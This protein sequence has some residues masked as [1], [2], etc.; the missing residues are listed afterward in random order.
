MKRSGIL[1]EKG[2]HAF[3]DEP[4]L[5][6]GH[7]IPRIWIL[8][9][10]RKSAHIYRRASSGLELIASSTARSGKSKPQ[11]L[12]AHGTGGG[13]HHDHDPVHEARHHQDLAFARGLSDWLE[14]AVR[15]RVVDRVVLIA[16][17]E[18]LGHLRA[19]FPKNVT[20]CVSAELR[21]DLVSL[22]EKTIREHLKD[23]VWF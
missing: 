3:D 13:I 23:I 1:I 21:K 5:Q 6:Q 22:P 14:E 15:E 8:V 18:F 19:N 10:D 9:A 4:R 20:S 7:E 2:L 12:K 16:P 17:P 11:A